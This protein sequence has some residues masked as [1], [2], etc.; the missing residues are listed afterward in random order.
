MVVIQ[1]GNFLMGSSSADTERD[2]AAVPPAPEGVT[3]KWLPLGFTEPSLA[4]KFMAREHP[5]HTVTIPKNFALGK[6]PVT[7]GE[8]AAFIQET[9]R[10]T[11]ACFIQFRKNGDY[12][13]AGWQHP[14]FAITDRD[15]AVCVNWY[16][17][18]A[19]IDW[20]NQKVAGGTAKGPY[21]L[22]TEAEWEYAARAG[23]RSA[24]WWGD[25]IGMDNAKCDGCQ[26]PCAR[27]EPLN[28]PHAYK[29]SPCA[30]EKWRTSPVG[31][32]PGN[33]FGLY[34]MQGNVWQLT[35]DCWNET[36]EGAPTDGAAWGSGNCATGVGTGIHTRPP[37]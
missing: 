26:A 4:T 27:A 32:Y 24:R 8:F 23:S 7:A 11:A 10:Q 18:Q 22:P 1:S 25:A 6:F 21:R 34:D 12:S 37:A 36:Y 15:P 29:P 5:Q 28:A 19:Y 17:A 13:G 2:F 35:G 30:A 3:S 14:G 20:L 33:P 16:D 31:S 9:K